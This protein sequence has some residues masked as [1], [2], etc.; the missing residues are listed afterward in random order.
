MP[1]ENPTGAGGAVA[2]PVQSADQAAALRREVTQSF[3]WYNRGARLWSVAYHLTQF[4]SALAGALAALWIKLDVLSRTTDAKD[5]SAALAASAAVM[6]TI[7][8][9]GRFQEKWRAN[10]R[11]RAS[12]KLLQLDLLGPAVDLEVVREKLKKIIELQSQE[13]SGAS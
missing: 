12:V 11:A 1:T 3:A 6:V 13:V 7:S 4:G 10:R 2:T 8:T 5:I 9:T